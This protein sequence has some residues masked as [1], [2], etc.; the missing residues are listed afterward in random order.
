MIITFV[1]SAERDVSVSLNLPFISIGTS[2]LGAWVRRRSRPSPYLLMS[3]TCGLAL[4]STWETGQG[5]WPRLRRP[6]GKSSQLWWLRSAGAPGEVYV[7]SAANGM[8]LDAGRDVGKEPPVL[9]LWPANATMSQRWKISSSPDDRAACL[10]NSGSGLVIDSPWESV[11]DSHPTMWRRHGGEN[12][13]W[14][15]AKPFTVRSE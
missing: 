5:V 10:T 7:V 13:H 6:N 12:Q 9:D 1:T 4:D 2:N 11:H 3:V 14:V 8:C 15:I